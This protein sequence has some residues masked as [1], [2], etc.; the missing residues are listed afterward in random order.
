MGLER[1]SQLEP[2]LAPVMT[3]P[4]FHKTLGEARSE[5]EKLFFGGSKNNVCA[6]MRQGKLGFVEIPRCALTAG[7]CPTRNLIQ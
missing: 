2:R 3:S 5:P 7:S 6:E 4:A 1:W